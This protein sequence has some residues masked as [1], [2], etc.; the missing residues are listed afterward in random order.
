MESGFLSL[1]RFFAAQLLFLGSRSGRLRSDAPD[2]FQ[3]AQ[4]DFEVSLR[5]ANQGVVGRE[6]EQVMLGAEVQVFEV[7][8]V[9][10]LLCRVRELLEG[11][12][13]NEAFAPGLPGIEALVVF[14]VVTGQ[15]FIRAVPE[16]PDGDVIVILA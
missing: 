4:T 1:L 16:S 14:A 13:G 3:V 6:G 10:L 11:F 5:V 7:G 9:Q 2:K 8:T 12:A 15:Q